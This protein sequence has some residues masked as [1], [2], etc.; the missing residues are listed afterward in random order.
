MLIG[1]H[2]VAF[3]VSLAASAYIGKRYGVLYGVAAGIV[4]SKA[5]VAVWE[6]ASIGE[7]S[8]IH[9]NTGVIN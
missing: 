9:A 4:A 3:A 5:T 2:G 7:S 1:K 6:I 8:T